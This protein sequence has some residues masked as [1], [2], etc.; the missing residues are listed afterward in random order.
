MLVRLLYV[1]RAVSPDSPEVIE[2]ILS[3]F[4]AQFRHPEPVD[5]VQ[6]RHGAA[7]FTSHR[8]NLSAQA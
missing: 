4:L 8:P 6:R 7:P 5:H 1:S 2:S 3:D